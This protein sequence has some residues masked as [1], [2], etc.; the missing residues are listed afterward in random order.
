MPFTIR[1]LQDLLRLLEQ[2]PEW[3]AEIRRQVLTE[4]LLELPALVRE[5]VAAQRRTDERLAELTRRTDERLAELAEAQRRTDERLAELAEAQRRTD[6]HLAELTRR[7]DE[8]FAEARQY[9]DERF[10]EARRHT[11]ERFAEM[12]EAQ[13]RTDERLAELTRRTD[14][15]FAELAAAIA[16]LTGRVNVLTDRVGT[17]EGDMLEMRYDRRGPIYFSR[18][19]RRLRVVDPARLVDL[20]DDAVERGRLTESERQAVL[21]ADVV[22]SGR[23]REDQ[24][25]VY[26]L[27]EVSSRIDLEDIQRAVERAAILAKLGRPVLPVVAGRRISPEV[28]DDAR[29]RGVHQVIDGH[30]T[31]PRESA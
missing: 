31:S 25:E 10:A 29:A 4:D 28:S 24:A 16:V 19:A 13:R 1:D 15:R 7:M 30:T 23:H 2:H 5:L 26:L 9:T 6:E 11:D 22:L 8:R 12:A 27:V 21:N 3:R 18:L 14:E 20:L 17:L